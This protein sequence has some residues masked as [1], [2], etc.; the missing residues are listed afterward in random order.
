MARTLKDQ[1][2]AQQHTPTASSFPQVTRLCDLSV[3]GD[4]VTSVGWSERVSTQGLVPGW[5]GPGRGG[6]TGLCWE[7]L[8]TVFGGLNPE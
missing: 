2:A 5:A 8:S 3:E 1:Q 7:G 6:L 4:S